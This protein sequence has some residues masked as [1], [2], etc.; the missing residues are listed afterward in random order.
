[1]F[2]RLLQNWLRRNIEINA[3]M[4]NH[5]ESV[6]LVDV[7]L[8]SLFIGRVKIHPPAKM[9]GYSFCDQPECEGIHHVKL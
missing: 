7:S 2:K 8:G 1:M 5:K 9:A 3:Y 4:G 6:V